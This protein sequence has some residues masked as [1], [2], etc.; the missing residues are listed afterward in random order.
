MV[1]AM[2]FNN[3]MKHTNYFPLCQEENAI[4]NTFFLTIVLYIDFASIYGLLLSRK[5]YTIDSILFK[6]M[7][8]KW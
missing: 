5:Y 8:Y 6:K 3:L 7:H 2:R 1:D 4:Y